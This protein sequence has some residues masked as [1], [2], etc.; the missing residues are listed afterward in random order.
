MEYPGL[1]I[2]AT[3]LLGSAFLISRLMRVSGR[4]TGSAHGGGIEQSQW[5]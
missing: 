1:L 5:H 2:F 3:F 4:N